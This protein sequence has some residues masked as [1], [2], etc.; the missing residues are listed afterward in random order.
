LAIGKNRRAEV[1]VSVASTHNARPRLIVLAVAAAAIAALVALTAGG[2]APTANAQGVAQAQELAK[3]SKGGKKLRSVIAISN[4]WD[5]TIDFAD[6]RTFK[7]LERINVIP[8][9]DE[10]MAEIMLDPVALGFFLG[11]REL[12]GEGNDQFV[13]DAFLHPNGRFIYV[14]RPSFADVVAINLR[15]EEIRWRTK[16]A[17]V[18]ADHMAISEDGSEVIVSASTG[19]VGQVLDTKTG[20]IIKEFESGDS[21]HETNYSADG[22]LLYHAAIGRVYTPTDEAQL[23]T[24]KGAT[25]FQIVDADTMEIVER[26][27]MQKKLEEAGHPGMSDAVRPMALSPNE[28]HLYAQVSFFHGFVDY[29]FKKDRVVR[30]IRLPVAEA[31]E[32]MP[33]EQYLLDSAH[34]GIALDPTGKRFCVAGTMSDYAAIVSRR[35]PKRRKIIPVGPK[36]YWSTN[37]ADGKHC[38][39]SV[40]G[41]DRVAVISYR[42][43][44]E[45][46]S[47]PVGDHPQRVRTGVV[48]NKYLKR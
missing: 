18:R 13:D 14:S 7:V 48:V 2:P 3:A 38:Y 42:K 26:I 4:N 37:S 23:D 24:S 5:G 32:N 46:A 11:I 9:R 8:D 29:N 19:N 31:I 44:K 41:S 22:E 12:I 36:P 33:K 40:S 20:E 21:P 45:I 30:V 28:R 6:E 47:I 35:K 25:F 16:V 34:H 10:R 27:H 1:T 39:V 17:G 43:R 15:T